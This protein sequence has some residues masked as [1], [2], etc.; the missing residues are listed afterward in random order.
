[1]FAV[2]GNFQNTVPYLNSR[3]LQSEIEVGRED[4]ISTFLLRAL[5]PRQERRFQR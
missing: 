3:H 4:E 1:M 5:A 2:T